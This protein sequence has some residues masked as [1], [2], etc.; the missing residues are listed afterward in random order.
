MHVAP[1]ITDLVVLLA[2]SLPVVFLCQKLG[3]PALVGFLLTGIV[4]GPSATGLIASVDRVET[5]AEVGVVLLLFTIGLE[6]SLSTLARM[7]RTVFGSGSLQVVATAALAA[8]AALA[9]GLTP[10][11]ALVLGFVAALSSS[12][13]ALKILSDRGESETP[14]GQMAL[15]VLLL[16]DFAVLPMLLVLPA[17]GGST[18]LGGGQ[19]VWALLTAGLAAV[20][21]VFAARTLLPL[22]F[23]Q[24][25]KLHS[26]ELFTGTVVLACFGTAWLAGVSGLSLAIGGFIAGLVVSE[27]EVS[28]QVVAE[29]IPLRDLFASVFFVAAGMLLDLGFV[30]AHPLLVA[31]AVGGLVLFK[32]A[33]GGIAVLAVRPSLRLAVL[34]GATLAQIGEFSFVLAAEAH[35]AGLLEPN[36]FQLVL[37]VAALTMLLSPFLV[38]GASRLAPRAD[39]ALGDGHRGGDKLP[40]SGHV[41]IVGYGLNGRNLARVLSETS[42]PYCVVDLDGRATAGARE[43]GHPVLYG[44]ATRVLVLRRAGVAAANVV[45]VAIR[46]AAATRRIVSLVRA[47]NAE[48]SIVVRTHYVAEIEDLYRLGASEV[49]PE[50]FETSVEIFSRVLQRLDIP[51]NVIAAQIDVLRAEHYAVLRGHGSTQQYIDSLYDIFMAATTV[52]YLLREG[53]PAVGATLEGLDLRR[54]TGA[55]V[56]ALVRGGKATTNPGMRTAFTKGDILVL[57]GNHAE[58]ASARALLDPPSDAPNGIP[59]DA[60]AD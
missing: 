23:A 36:D 48:A 40:S 32:W 4:I 56:I 10:A 26:R 42:I 49:I 24:V 31:A 17:L 18:R 39:V 20:L 3:L 30:A 54:A 5:L 50:E 44:D 1:V 2:T 57:L 8:A 7:R 6:V 21:I 52:T 41:A 19:I 53:S 29:V 14:H 35:D 22:V 37:A 28:H 55:T 60:P 46:D 58:I 45:V 34:A 33:I 12:A 25:L 27:S 51:K 47:M 13:V 11:R 15:G 43:E 16:Q 38:G 9:F 59:A